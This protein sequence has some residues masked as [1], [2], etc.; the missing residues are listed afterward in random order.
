MSSH[1]PYV[2]DDPI[3]FEK[4]LE[5]DRESMELFAMGL[6]MNGYAIIL[7]PDKVAKT[8]LDTQRSAMRFFCSNSLEQ[9]NRFNLDNHKFRHG[10]W[11]TPQFGKELFQ[12]RQ[13]EK[14]A[15]WPSAK[16]RQQCEACFSALKR[17]GEVCLLSIGAH[18]NSNI[19]SRAGADKEAKKGW[20]AYWEN[21][22]SGCSPTDAPMAS[23]LLDIF[24]YYKASSVCDAKESC[25]NHVDHGLLTLVPRALGVAGLEVYSWSSWDWVAV[26][27]LAK[28]QNECV[29]FAGE[30]LPLITDGWILPANHRVVV[31]AEAHKEATAQREADTKTSRI[32]TPFL[33]FANPKRIL[34]ATHAGLGCKNKASLG[35]KKM[36]R[37]SSSVH[38]SKKNEEDNVG[39]SSGDFVKKIVASTASVTF[40]NKHVGVA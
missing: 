9:K 14:E 36:S 40:G 29:V 24:R 33:L 31:R 30:S 21:L 6:K 19:P 18:L 1:P 25:G 28:S 2:P 39:I 7:L 17:V 5:T 34:K 23:S 3:P 16:F 35:N 22:S 13:T 32:S 10:Y 11:S 12:V 26:E 27:S 38:D 4:L 8:V 15:N 37:K 20:K